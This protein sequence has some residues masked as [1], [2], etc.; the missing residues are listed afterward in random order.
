[1]G[2]ALGQMYSMIFNHV[3][4]VLSLDTISIKVAYGHIHTFAIDHMGHCV[5]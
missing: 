2:M 1:M 5:W 3:C 4:L